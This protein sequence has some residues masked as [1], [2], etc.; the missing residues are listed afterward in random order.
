MEGSIVMYNIY[1]MS[2]IHGHYHYVRDFY[3]RNKEEIDKYDNNVLI[4]CGDVGANYFKNRRDDDF[5]AALGNYPFIYFC[6]R[7]NHEYRAYDM[8][9]VKPE[10]WEME[11]FFDN[12]VMVEKKYPYIKYAWD[13]P[14]IY[15]INKLKT[16]VFPGAYSVDKFHRIQNGWTWVPNE[17]LDYNEMQYGR[18][19]LPKCNYEVD[20]VLS[21]TCPIM[22][23]PTDLFLPSVDQNLVDKTMERYLGEIEWRVSYKAWCWGHFHDFRDNTLGGRRRLMLYNTG[24]VRLKDVMKIDKKI[25]EL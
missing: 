11:I 18:D 16:L 6:V 10:E 17:Q 13:I 15:T 24:A 7:G 8:L 21:H 5:K 4:F 1:L 9:Q 25:K 14:A 23:E 3:N 22:C 2:D 20:L 12:V 19:L